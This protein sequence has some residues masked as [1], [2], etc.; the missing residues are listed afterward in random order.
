M[1]KRTQKQ[2]S[3]NKI[4]WGLSYGARLIAVCTI[5]LAA[6]PSGWVRAVEIPVLQTQNKQVKVSGTVRDD[7]GEPL[8]GA[9]IIVRGSTRYNTTTDADGNFQITVPEG[10]VLV[11]SYLG[12]INV[13]KAAGDHMEIVMEPDAQKL[14][15]LVV[16][17]YTKQNMRDVSAS[18]AKIDMQAIEHNTSVSLASML[19]GQAAGLQTVTRSGVPGASNT[20]IVI[21]GNNSLSSSNDITGISNPLYIVDGIPMPLQD[22][23][24]YNVTDNDFLSSL[25]PQDIQSINILKDAAAT[26]IYGSRGANGVVIITTHKGTSGKARVTARINGGFIT[27]P[28]KLPVYVGQEEREAKLNIINQT[29]TNLYGNMP[30]FDVRQA[31]LLEILG[32]AVPAVL[33]DKYNPAFN[34]AY[35]YQDMFYQNGSTQNYDLSME[36]GNSSNSYRISLGHYNEKG[37]LVGYGLSRTNLNASLVTDVNKYFHNELIIRYSYLDRQGGL[38]DKMKAMP[39]SPTELPSSLFYRTPEELRQLS[40]Q[41]G[42]AYNKNRSHSLSLGETLR[43]KFL[44]NLTLDNQVSTILDFG[45]RDYF[46]PSTATTDNKSVAYSSASMT[47]SMNANSVLNFNTTLGK[48]GDHAIIVLAG[49]EA[50]SNDLNQLRVEATNGMSDYLKVVQGFKKEDI[51][52]YSDMVKSNM[53]SFFTMVSYG[54]KNNRYKIEGVFRHDGSSRFGSNKKWASFP[55]IK[56]H[57]A[58][59]EEP[60][61]SAMKKW[62]DFGKVRVSFGSSGEIYWDPLLQYNSLIALSSISGGLGYMNSNKMDVKTYGGKLSLVS[63]FDKIANKDLSW[64]RSKEIDYGLDLE[65]FN[66]RVVAT[67]DLYSKYLS[68]L[69]YTSTL[70]AYVGFNKVSSN[71]VDMVSNGFEVSLTTYLF[72]RT[73]AVQWDWTLNIGNN[74]TRIAKMGNGGKDYINVDEYY[75]FSEGAPAFQY[76]MYE[77][78]GTL[79]N[80]SDLP[81]DPF[82]GRALQ[83]TGADAGLGRNLQG[84]IFPGMP[85]FTDV[86]GDFY[87]DG[88]NSTTDRKIITGK[89]PEPKIVGGLQTGFRYKNLA[90]RINT[91]FAFGHWIVNSTLQ[92]QLSRFDSSQEFFQYALYQFDESKFWTKPGDGSYYPM[93]YVDYMDGGSARSFRMSSMF[94]ERGDYWSIDNITL[95]YNL[96]A[97]WVDAIKMRAINVN[98]TGSN[99]F[100]WKASQVPDPRMISR[101]GFYNGSG[102]PISK[103]FVLGVQLQF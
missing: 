55:S 78:A 6:C 79:D 53:L 97:K 103:T 92:Q 17:G 58:F 75:A 31:A 45:K 2:H 96:P 98:L 39:T 50:N 76:Y 15:A 88:S 102:Y 99:L 5:G 100:M 67:V 40:G 57:W 81:V 64:S 52:A 24:G 33:T 91:S 85:I 35:D 29:L 30:W 19:A 101:T 94:L 82:T 65:L 80:Y 16:V 14:D 47:M 10:S 73:S 18:V 43:I 9:Y 89:T 72:P 86:N 93:I 49:V 12:Y 44:E 59:S 71:L 25:N 37:V 77:Y 21:R 23:A 38:N 26:A 90:V 28:S 66:H 61:M 34:N 3:R 60:W 54:Y 68:G 42:D 22:I 20:G 69:V 7:I 4:R 74:R 63:D 32:Y 8:P 70:P 83:Y 62:L 46:I 56:T 11:F 48:N 41:L 13:E 87:V 84:R 1:S 36:G 51:D 27:K 95:S